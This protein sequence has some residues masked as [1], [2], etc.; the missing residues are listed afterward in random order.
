VADPEDHPMSYSVL[1]F[2]ITLGA[3]GGLALLPS[4]ADPPKASSQAIEA[5][6]EGE[7][8]EDREADLEA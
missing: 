4:R 6:L 5:A 8:F 1:L 7:A 3:Y 2:V